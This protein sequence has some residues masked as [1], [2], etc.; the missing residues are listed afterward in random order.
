MSLATDAPSAPPPADQPS[1]TIDRR[2]LLV[3]AG[4]A[5]SGFLGYR[6]VRGWFGTK[7]PVF[8]ARNQ[9]YDG[10]LVQT[11]HDGLLATGLKPDELTG[12]RVLLKPN[13]VEPTRASP[14][15]TTHPA[16]VLAASEVFRRWGASVSVGEA[17]GHV[18]DT[19]MALVESGLGPA[20]LG[21]KVE[22][23]DLN[24]EDVA[25]RVNRGGA[26]KL[27]GF[28]FPRSIAEADLVVSMPKLKTHHWVGMTASLKNLYGTL[29]GIKYGWPKNVLHHAGIPQT[30]V[31]INASVGRTLAIVDGIVCMEG[32]GPILGTAKP[33]GLLV[34]GLNL[35]AVDATCARLMQL[36]PRMITYLNLAAG[37][38]GPLDERLIPQRGERW[39][40]LSSPFTILDRE[41]LRELRALRPGVLTS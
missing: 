3:G 8:V 35:T 5:A 10:S 37:K 32:D 28:F 16:V 38:L 19:E 26:S 12:K 30:V 9:S 1:E 24:Y 11:I 23:A 33:M 41:H 4:A 20:L 13:L 7:H 17:P 39:Q 6:L 36:E 18:R 14:Q 29:P 25:W 21:E 27:E 40:E 31:D 15:M 2:S 34:M 22:F